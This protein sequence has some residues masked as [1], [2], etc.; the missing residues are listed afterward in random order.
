MPLT[1]SSGESARDSQHHHGGNR[2]Y[3]AADHHGPAPPAI[4]REDGIHSIPPGREPGG[5]GQGRRRDSIVTAR[6]HALPTCDQ[7]L[8]QWQ[9]CRLHPLSPSA[10]PM[11][12]HGKRHSHPPKV[13]RPTCAFG[14]MSLVWV[15]TA[16]RFGGTLGRKPIEP[17]RVS[18]AGLAPSGEHCADCPRTRRASA[19]QSLGSVDGG[20]TGPSGQSRGELGTVPRQARARRMR[21]DRHFTIDAAGDKA[22]DRDDGRRSGH[23]PEQPLPFGGRNRCISSRRSPLIDDRA[24]HDRGACHQ[25]S[26]Q[27]DRYVHKG[28]QRV[29][30]PARLDSTSSGQAPHPPGPTSDPVPPL[31]G[32]CLGPDRTKAQLS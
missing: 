32:S 20:G 7:G 4:A 14:P 28:P 13:S 17:G 8:R 24:D 12:G 22:A 5:P 6:I 15:M 26:G 16:S 9:S 10:G 31:R 1:A 19:G 18:A 25:D 2:C 3:R 11:G 21:L 23:R 27:A 30:G 29:R